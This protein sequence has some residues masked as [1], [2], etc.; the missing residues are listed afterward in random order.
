MIR[1]ITI[2]REF[3]SGGSE[4]ARILAERLEWKLIDDPL[5]AEIAHRAD[6]SPDLARRYDE[7]VDPWFHRMCKALWRGGYEGVVSRGELNAFDADAMAD[8]WRR[9]IRESAELGHC[10]L[11]GR[12]A[13]CLLQGHKDVFHVSVFAEMDERVRN[14]R[15]PLRRHVPAGAD[16]K[17]MAAESDQRRA[18]YVRR[19]FGED[20][21]DHRLYHLV[22]NSAVGFE[23]AAAAILSAAGLTARQ[24]AQPS[25]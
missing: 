20:W 7:C 11:V 25:A 2:S 15:G 16:P 24:P 19:Y 6:V 12:G 22:I 21:K 9:V 17:T 4:V 1:V 18:N 10:V 3:G 5:V 23:A 13:Q 14:L 8:L